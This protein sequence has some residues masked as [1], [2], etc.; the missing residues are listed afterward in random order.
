MNQ[1][2]LKEYCDKKKAKW[3]LKNFDKVNVNSDRKDDNFNDT[4]KMIKNYLGEIIKSKNGYVERKYISKRNGKGRMYLDKCYGYQSMM[5]EYRHTLCKDE[6]YDIDIKNCHPVLLVQYCEKNNIKCD[7]LAEYVEK[8]EKFNEYLKKYYNM[9]AKK[10]S[11]F[12]MNGCPLFDRFKKDKKLSSLYNEIKKIHDKIYELNKEIAEYV[13]NKKDDNIKGSCCAYLLQEIENEILMKAYEFFKKKKFEIGSLCF[14]G[15]M[16][17]KNKL[18]NLSILKELKEYIRDKINYGVDF[19]IK[20]MNQGYDITDEDLKEMEIEDEK[21]KENEYI[22][23]TDN[24]G[25]LLILEKLKNNVKKSK[26]RFFIKKFENCNIYK[27]DNTNSF[28]ET[29]DYI[30]NFI[31]NLDIKK[32]NEKGNL[33]VYSQD[34]IGAS[35][36]LRAVMSKIE[37]DDLFI[38]KMWESNLYKL[39]FINGYYDFKSNTFKDY[40][41]DTYTPI[42]INYEYKKADEDKKKEIYDKILNPIFPNETQRNYVLYWLSR[43][44]AGC[45]TDKTWACGLGLRDSGKGVITELI[46]ETLESY[47]GTFSADEFTISKSHG[48]DARRK[49]FLL[50]FEFRRLNMS[51]E[52]KTIEGDGK[53]VIFDGNLIKT[54][55]SGGDEIQA[56]PLFRNTTTIRS[57]GRFI[58]F[59][60]EDVKCYPDDCNEKLDIFMFENVFKKCITEEDEKINNR[61]GMKILKADDNI[62]FLIKNK[63]YKL[64]MLEIL[65]ESFSFNILE[66]PPCVLNNKLDVVDKDEN[67]EMKLKDYVEITDDKEDIILISEVNKHLKQYF[68]L[69]QIKTNLAKMGAVE[70]KNSQRYYRYLKLKDKD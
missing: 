15:L 36:L 53:Q 21:N 12:M 52:L 66:R 34:I 67:I 31:L 17:K 26:G 1:I 51:N 5:R 69:S 18:I 56:R 57:Q 14:D 38:K 7:C 61:G 2:C 33:R 20:E 9:D 65:I 24:E 4:I 10:F 41:D 45:Y 64:A 59:L 32:I 3:V 28:Q 55:S 62:K 54:A 6:Y 39:C 8:R 25:S 70:F 63:D 11:L 42:Y 49:A 48:D 30:L 16:I 27:E 19:V 40:D 29:K 58:C 68:K 50:P 13:E 35:S 46:L 43:G 23:E 60:N 22:I 44:M 47:A 37:E